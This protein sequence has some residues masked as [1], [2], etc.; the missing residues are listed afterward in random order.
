MGASFLDQ[1]DRLREQAQQWLSQAR[2]RISEDI[3]SGILGLSTPRGVEANRS[4][5]QKQKGFSVPLFALFP[6]L[7]YELYP[8]VPLEHYQELSLSICLYM[9]YMIMMDRLMDGEVM[10]EPSVAFWLTSIHQRAMTLLSS[11][12]PLDSPL[13]PYFD[14]C[15]RENTHA[16]T[17]ERVKH[18]FRVS[19]Y[20]EEEIVL[21]TAGRNAM[22]KAGIAAL[23]FLAHQDVPDALI[24][25]C[26]AFNVGTNLLDDLQDW[27][28]DYCDHLYT[29]LLT[30]VI[31][32]RGLTDQIEGVNRL[33]VNTIGSLIYTRGY[34]Q[35][36]VA[37]ATDYLKLALH[38]AQGMDCP[39]WLDAILLRLECCREE[40]ETKF[41]KMQEIRQKRQ[42][43]ILQE[44][45]DRSFVPSL[46]AC[47]VFPGYEILVTGSAHTANLSNYLERYGKILAG[48]WQATDT[49]AQFA[50]ANL[51]QYVQQ[52]P[53]LVPPAVE[54]IRICQSTVARCYHIAALPQS[55]AIYLL[56][57]GGTVDI[58][59]FH[60]DGEWQMAVALD[61]WIYPPANARTHSELPQLETLTRHVRKKVAYEYGRTLCLSNAQSPATLLEK[62][63]LEGRA[64]AFACEVCPDIPWEEH[65]EL[66]LGM[67]GWFEHNKNYLW[68]EAQGFLESSL[69]SV[70][71]Y[72]LGRGMNV[73]ES[74]M[75]PLAP[76]LGRLLGHDIVFS[77]RQRIG[78]QAWPK[79]MQMPALD[80]LSKGRGKAM[81]VASHVSGTWK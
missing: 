40:S 74:E 6:F 49:L 47:Q 23:A 79:L 53:A 55:I 8:Q 81:A 68:Q 9:E 2:S 46:P 71:D 38:Y 11:L 21:I 12:F 48:W 57:G 77:Y 37:Q 10:L 35:A 39:A 4:L 72:Y 64:L 24:A 18:T 26:E 75:F 31:L 42:T 22:A 15:R 65:A 25:S 69:A 62:M 76:Y 43:E 5:S 33:D 56:V 17:L 34:H 28:S 73:P 61:R 32:D 30:Q 20:S 1:P 52:S 54:M 29:P 59:S 27:R 66:P 45:P 67:S 14:Q 50:Q 3:N 58:A 7:F 36:F 13:W 80:I 78:Q 19:P 63:C 70:A 44:T 60:S 41:T 51:Q 16:L